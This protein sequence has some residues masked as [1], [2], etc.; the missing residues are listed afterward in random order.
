MQD[1]QSY[2]IDQQ[3]E[4]EIQILIVGG[5]N[6]PPKFPLTPLRLLKVNASYILAISVIL[7]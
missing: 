3:H 2:K 4:D 7:S 5:W 1:M 6:G